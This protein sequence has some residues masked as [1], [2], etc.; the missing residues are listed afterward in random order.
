MFDDEARRDT[1]TCAKADVR[2][3]RARGRGRALK[4]CEMQPQFESIPISRPYLPNAAPGVPRMRLRKDVR[5]ASQPRGGAARHPTRT[6][7]M[8]H[9]ARPRRGQGAR[10][11]SARGR[12]VR[13][14][15]QITRDNPAQH[16][17]THTHNHNHG[18]LEKVRNP[19]EIVLKVPNG[20]RAAARI[21]AN[22][23]DVGRRP[24]PSSLWSVTP[25]SPPRATGR[26]G[27]GSA[28]GA[29]GRR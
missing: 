10:T 5:P 20:A 19:K 25:C 4:L 11:R 18:T 8:V 23:C 3:T 29:R 24:V 9:T 17:H 1:Q 26:T 2:V 6:A 15:T 16:T 12:P 14:G 27:Q 28:R 13:G 21:H 7:S 22:A